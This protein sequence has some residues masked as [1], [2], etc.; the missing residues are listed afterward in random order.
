MDNAVLSMCHCIKTID[1]Q[2]ITTS[3]FLAAAI[4]RHRPF[5][6]HCSASYSGSLPMLSQVWCARR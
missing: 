4:L 5:S 1:R 3:T 2:N 6:S